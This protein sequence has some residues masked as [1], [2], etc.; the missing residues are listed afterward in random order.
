MTDEVYCR[1]CDALPGIA[2]K[3]KP[4]RIAEDEA[5]PIPEVFKKAL[6]WLAGKSDEVLGG[7]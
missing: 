2:S 4:A 5:H 7:G 6:V 1:K 3:L